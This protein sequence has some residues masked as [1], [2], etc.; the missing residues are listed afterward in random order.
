MTTRTRDGTGQDRTGQDR[1]GQDRTG[2]DRTG[3][4]GT[5]RDRTG[6]DS[7]REGIKMVEWLCAIE[8]RI[9]RSIA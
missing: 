8:R 9:H 3:R 1:T 2:R 7:L 4:D 5:G 6:Q